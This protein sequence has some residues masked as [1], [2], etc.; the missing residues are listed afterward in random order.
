MGRVHRSGCDG[1]LRVQS[2]AEEVAL[3]QDRVRPAGYVRAGGAGDLARQR[4]AIVAGARQRGWPAPVVYVEADADLAAGRAPE[5]ERLQAAIE[6]GRHDALLI[7]DP[8]AVT[9]TATHLM[10]LL[11]RC[12]R[13]GVVVGFLLPPAVAQLGEAPA[14]PA[15]GRS[16]PAPVQRTSRP[17]AGS[18]P[19][20]GKGRV[21][22]GA[23]SRLGR[24]R[25]PA[26]PGRHI[27]RF[28]GQHDAL[29]GSV[30]A[31]LGQSLDSGGTAILVAAPAHRAAV[32]ARIT[33]A[34]GDPAAARGALVVL[35]AA[36]TLQRFQ[37]GG[38]LDPAR[39]RRVI[40]G[41]I[42]A[43]ATPGRRVRV[44]GEMVALLWD[45]GDPAAVIHLEALWNDLATRI[46][47]S[48][49]C[50]YPA[51]S[52]RGQQHA[53]ALDQVCGLHSVILDRP[54]SGGS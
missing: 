19:A 26:A 45:S 29:A 25:G 18:R 27:V 32:E 48:L 37:V 11:L 33:A 34:A 41:L 49:M 17:A 30:A 4:G 54:A 12:T 38:H 14:G 22:H 39:F 50:A 36:S 53:E 44:Y 23:G 31:Y 42:R 28:Y 1:I 43:T 8:G 40:G 3:T 10:G 9:G 51:S 5:L 7:T 20:V 24:V 52:V 13:N 46:E 16:Q 2:F 15:G 47:F 6:S 35:D 21:G